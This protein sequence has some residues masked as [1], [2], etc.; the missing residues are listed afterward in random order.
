[1]LMGE[2]DISIQKHIGFIKAEMKKKT[3][4]HT[5]LK[6][7]MKR[8]AAYRQ[9]FCNENNTSVVLETFPCLQLKAFVSY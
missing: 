9:K 1:M 2:D 3:P 6:D 8:T 7:S 5:V 4:D